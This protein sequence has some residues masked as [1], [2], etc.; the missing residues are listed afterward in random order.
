MLSKAQTIDWLRTLEIGDKVRFRADCG[1]G[2]GI[3]TVR[4]STKA[5]AGKVFVI[6]HLGG[7][8]G[9]MDK[10]IL[11]TYLCSNQDGLEKSWCAGRFEP[12]NNRKITLNTRKIY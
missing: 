4:A 3:D 12:V 9:A 10:N 5:M 8:R 7:M 1:A 2:V 6:V 11:E